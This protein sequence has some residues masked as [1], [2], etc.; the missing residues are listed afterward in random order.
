MIT[1][2][3]RDHFNVSAVDF[4]KTGAF[5]LTLSTDTP[6]FVNPKL[7]FDYDPALRDKV[8]SHFEKLIALLERMEDPIISSKDY[9]AAFELIRSRETA[10]D[11]LGPCENTIR[12]NSFGAALGGRVLEKAKELSRSVRLDPEAFEMLDVFEKGVGCDRISDLLVHILRDDFYDYNEKIIKQLFLIRFPSVEVEGGS[13]GGGAKRKYFLLENPRFKEAQIPIV[14]LPKKILSEIGQPFFLDQNHLA[15]SSAEL[16]RDM[17]GF[18]DFTKTPGSTALRDSISAM[19]KA[20]PDSYRLIVEAYK[21]LKESPYD[22]SSDPKGFQSW[23]D[24]VAS[25]LDSALLSHDGPFETPSSET[26]FL[27]E[28]ARKLIETDGKWNAFAKA[29]LGRI[30]L[31][32]RALAEAIGAKAGEDINRTIG[33]STKMPDFWFDKNGRKVLFEIRSMG[34]NHVVDSLGEGGQTESRISEFGC[35]G[36]F[37]LIL[38]SSSKRSY[39]SAIKAY[40]DMPAERKA[41]IKALF[42]DLDAMNRAPAS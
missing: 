17:A 29:G 15:A 24:L 19:I 12:G 3:F 40:G 42:V 5:N 7:L 13:D 34:E 32:I 28:T 35:E 14:L 30:H 21:N 23:R 1:E 27:G 41:R 20:N 4:E 10:G 38:G 2:T 9:E 26:A 8:R 22:F 36:A 31:A 39:G 25:L 33:S 6:L 16:R 11:C 37:E 18:F